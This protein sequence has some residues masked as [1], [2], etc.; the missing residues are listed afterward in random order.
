MLTTLTCDLL[1][2]TR[3][4]LRMARAALDWTADELA[5]RAGVAVNTIRRMEKGHGALQETVLKI[6]RT[7]EAEGLEFIA[8]DAPSLGGG[9]GVRFRKTG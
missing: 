6:Q 1:G 4:Q 8:A 9:A 7:F 3:E 2:M 5:A